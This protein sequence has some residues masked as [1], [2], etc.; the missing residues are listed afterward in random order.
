[1]IPPVSWF[2]PCYDEESLP[3]ALQDALGVSPAIAGIARWLPSGRTSQQIAS[4][5]GKSVH[6]VKVQA[7]QLEL[8]MGVTTRTELAGQI[9]AAVWHRAWMRGDLGAVRPTI[10]GLTPQVLR[11]GDDAHGAIDSRQIMP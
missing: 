3:P 6:T 9:V 8:A 7:R 11:G 1:M 4:A 5:L 10:H 2:P